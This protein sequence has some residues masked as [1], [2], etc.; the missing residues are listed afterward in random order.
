ML[1]E[2]LGF[3]PTNQPTIFRYQS[4]RCGLRLF[5]AYVDDCLI[6]GHKSVFAWV[7][8]ELGKRFETKQTGALPAGAVGSLDLLGR[9][10]KREE[11]KGWLMLAWR[12]L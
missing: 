12:V 9:V 7:V 11:A 2:E 5:L 4:A 10:I 1:L 6:I 3:S 8:Q